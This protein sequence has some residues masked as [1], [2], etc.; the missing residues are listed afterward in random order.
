[1]QLLHSFYVF[2][3]KLLPSVIITYNILINNIFLDTHFSNSHQ[4][5]KEK[6]KRF[7]PKEVLYIE[8]N[9]ASVQIAD[10]LQCKG[11]EMYTCAL[12]QAKCNTH[13]TSYC[14]KRTHTISATSKLQNFI[15]PHFPLK[16]N[17]Q[18]QS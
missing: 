6:K 5:K 2:L 18:W 4:K 10:I 16:N 13:C 11:G 1:M 7:I 15:K 12:L 17:V 3:D 14:Q 9:M 8:H